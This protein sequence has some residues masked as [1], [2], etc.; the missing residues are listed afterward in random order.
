MVL[1][2]HATKSTYIYI[3]LYLFIKV[4]IFRFLIYIYI[5]LYWRPI[6]QLISLTFS[7]YICPNGSWPSGTGLVSRH[8]RSWMVNLA[9]GRK[10]LLRKGVRKTLKKGV[11]GIFI[12]AGWGAHCLQG[13]PYS[14]QDGF[15]EETSEL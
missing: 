1:C 7:L 8:A 12:R 5:Q 9:R 11:P 10:S 3:Y 15:G 14:I 2:G 6:F 4:P 13:I